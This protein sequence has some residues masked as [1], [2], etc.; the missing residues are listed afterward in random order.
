MWVELL[1]ITK[2]LLNDTLMWY[3]WDPTWGFDIFTNEIIQMLVDDWKNSIEKSCILVWV[4]NEC[5]LN[6]NP[7]LKNC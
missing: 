5:G 3:I 2:E 6:L 1:S 4:D 7:S